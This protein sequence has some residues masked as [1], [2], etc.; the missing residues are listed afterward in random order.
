M[1]I[2][3]YEQRVKKVMSNVFGIDESLITGDASQ[4]TITNWNSLG[5]MNLVI[6]LEEEFSITFRD[7]QVI[8]MLSYPLIICTL[9]ER[10][11]EM[12]HKT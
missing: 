9:K 12:E 5:H 4:D 8:E 3:L 6:A 11:T 1:N 7:E 2:A 10:M